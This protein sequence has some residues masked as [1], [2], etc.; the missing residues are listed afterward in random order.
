MTYVGR[1]LKGLPKG[2]IIVFNQGITM[3]VLLLILHGLNY[4]D[5]QYQVLRLIHRVGFPWV[6]KVDKLIIMWLCLNLQQ[7]FYHGTQQG[8][9]EITVLLN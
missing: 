4:L 6:L 9:K 5:L 2:H 8:T 3:M 1:R 7:R